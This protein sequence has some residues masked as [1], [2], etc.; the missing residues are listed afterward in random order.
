MLA[1]KAQRIP[2]HQRPKRDDILPDYTLDLLKPLSRHHDH[3]KDMPQP[4]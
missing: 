1:R 4:G 2:R 3:T